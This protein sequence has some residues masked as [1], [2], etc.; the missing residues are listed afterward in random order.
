MFPARI[1]KMAT[2]RPGTRKPSKKSSMAE[3]KGHDPKS[4]NF[5]WR[6][7]DVQVEEPWGEGE[8]IPVIE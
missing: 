4:G 5:A 2:K 6:E 8:E 3:S 1:G 7:G